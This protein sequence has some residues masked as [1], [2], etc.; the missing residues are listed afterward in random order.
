MMIKKIRGF[1]V[2]IK[3]DL[4]E[5][6]TEE[7]LFILTPDGKYIFSLNEVGAFIWNALKHNR[8]G[9]EIVKDLMSIYD[10]EEGRL[11]RDLDVFIKELR[12]YPAELISVHL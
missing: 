5:K 4:I 10:V 9:D 8:P 7:G 1:T 3:G 11:A 6:K 12:R 2:K